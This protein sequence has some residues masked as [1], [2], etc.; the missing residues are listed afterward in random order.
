MAAFTVLS[1]IVGAFVSRTIIILTFS[2]QRISTTA[3]F[4]WFVFLFVSFR[5]LFFAKLVYE[6]RELKA[7][8][9][10]KIS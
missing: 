5:P 2:F 3:V 10:G 6:R 8:E 7:E 9:G 1:S 4:A